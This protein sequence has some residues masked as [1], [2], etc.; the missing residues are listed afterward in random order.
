MKVV[1]NLLIDRLD[2]TFGIVMALVETSESRCF[3]FYTE[4][5]INILKNLAQA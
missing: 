1:N 3:V 5:Y 2:G 4:V